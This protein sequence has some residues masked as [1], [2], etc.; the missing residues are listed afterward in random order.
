V[1]KALGE[2]EHG[3]DRRRHPEY[4]DILRHRYR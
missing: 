4:P 3:D 1:S 2:I